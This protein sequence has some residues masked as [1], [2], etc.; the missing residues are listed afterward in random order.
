MLTHTTLLIYKVDL[1]KYV[2]EKPAL[3]GKIAR[4]QMILTEYDIQYT[5][6]K[7]IKGS[8]LVDHLA[9]QDV[10]D[11]QSMRFNFPDEDIMTLDN[12]KDNGPYDGPEKG[13]RWT[14]YFDGASSALGNDINMVLISR[15]GCHTPFT[16]RLCFSCTNNMAEYEACIFGL[17]AAIWSQGCD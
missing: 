15:E 2:F 16:A 8:V 6:Q 1:I 3:S 13:S 14:L 4:W 9:H 10:E 17:K 5:T 7:A 11:Y 12:I